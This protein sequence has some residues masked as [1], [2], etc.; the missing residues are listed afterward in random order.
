MAGS[1]KILNNYDPALSLTRFHPWEVLVQLTKKYTK[2]C[3]D[4]VCNKGKLENKGKSTQMS[5][6]W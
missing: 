4:I 3:S 6:I 5:K 1:S 2:K